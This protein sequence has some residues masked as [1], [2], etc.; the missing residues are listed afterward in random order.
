MCDI[1]INKF[2]VKENPQGT[3]DCDNAPDAKSGSRKGFSLTVSACNGCCSVDMPPATATLSPGTPASFLRFFGLGTPVTPASRNRR[4]QAQQLAEAELPLAS[5]AMMLPPP[6]PAGRDDQTASSSTAASVPVTPSSVSSGNQQQQHLWK[7]F[8]GGNQIADRDSDNKTAVFSQDAR[9]GVEGSVPASPLS[10]SSSTLVLPT[11]E[12]VFSSAASTLPRDENE[13]A[14]EDK[15]DIAVEESNTIEEI[16]SGAATEQPESESIDQDTVSND[17]SL[18]EI[19]HARLDAHEQE[20]QEAVVASGVVDNDDDAVNTTEAVAVEADV[21]SPQREDEVRVAIEAEELIKDEDEAIEEGGVSREEE[22]VEEEDAAQEE[23]VVREEISE[24]TMENEMK[25]EVDQICELLHLDRP[26]GLPVGAEEPATAAA[27][28]AVA[29]TA[30]VEEHMAAM[31]LVSGTDEEAGTAGQLEV[32]AGGDETDVAVAT[33]S[34]EKNANSVH[35]GMPGVR[36]IALT[37]GL[38]W[39]VVAICAGFAVAKLV[40]CTVAVTFY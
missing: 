2:W 5:P 4:Q 27:A 14:V 25:N 33:K 38:G 18:N 19:K 35:G 21:S 37:T 7:P 34:D 15:E 40:R 26:V 13:E 24:M 16:A 28:A 23:D 31:D 3:C 12:K 8:F 9:E 6:T 10:P 39:S 20:M 17:N 36:M 11:D 22:A 32:D 30:G 29:D 1:C